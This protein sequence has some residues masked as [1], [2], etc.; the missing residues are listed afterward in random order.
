VLHVA[1]TY[2]KR[3]E[4]A[5]PI[6]LK[7]WPEALKHIRESRE[8]CGDF[9]FH[10]I[11]RQCAT[12]E[13][14]VKSIEAFVQYSTLDALAAGFLC[15]NIRDGYCFDIFVQALEATE[16]G[17]ATR[18]TPFQVDEMWQTHLINSVDHFVLQRRDANGRSI[19]HYIA[20]YD[21]VDDDLE[22]NRKF[23]IA[24]KLRKEYKEKGHEC[25][26]LWH[27][28]YGEEDDDEKHG[29]AILMWWKKRQKEKLT[30]I[31]Q[32]AE[33]ILRKDKDMALAVD[34]NGLNPFQY[35]VS[36]GKEWHHGLKIIAKRV[37]GW[38]Q[39]LDNDSLC[40]FAI[41]AHSCNDLNTVFELLRFEPS[42]LVTATR[43][44]DA[45]AKKNGADEYE[46]ESEMNNI[47]ESFLPLA[48]VLANHSHKATF[49][50]Q[51]EGMRIAAEANC[52][53]P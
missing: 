2:Y 35:A 28:P 34:V 3:P 33:W 11:F 31:G 51:L 50:S 39:Q 12:Y 41:A 47:M 27:D 48:K 52:D 32:I 16:V 37:P 21:L 10:N 29:L 23:E 14:L 38:A 25:P 18:Y 8:N 45:I 9:P 42:V 36:V 13:S 30:K 20:A 7:V 17:M 6:F 1:T 49:L 46:S 19:L 44:D 40:P 24:Q 26:F 4:G 5:L 43:G 22:G 53:L 15:D